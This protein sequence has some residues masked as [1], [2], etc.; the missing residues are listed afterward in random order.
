MSLGISVGNQF[1]NFYSQNS[2]E[3]QFGSMD[4]DKA[5]CVQFEYDGKLDEKGTNYIQCA[6]LYPKY[7][8][9][10]THFYSYY[11]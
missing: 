7:Y 6:V 11:L 9:I 4:C 2:V 3:L 1:G 8:F 5:F 10:T